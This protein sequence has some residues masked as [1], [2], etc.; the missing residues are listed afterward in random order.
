MPITIWNHSRHFMLLRTGYSIVYITSAPRLTP[1][2]D[3]RVLQ[4]P[5][6]TA[7]GRAYKLHTGGKMLYI[8]HEELPRTTDGTLYIDPCAPNG[9]REVELDERHIP[10]DRY[11]VVETKD[12][13]T[14]PP[15]RY[16]R[17][18]SALRG[19]PHSSATIINPGSEGLH[20][21]EFKVRK[22]TTI[23]RGMHVANLYV[24]EPSNH[25]GLQS[26]DRG[27]YHRRKSIVPKPLD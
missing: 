27:H 17:I 22:P 18:S 26:Y 24:F 1:L 15:H 4:A 9:F 23:Y 6:R 10:A 14:M 2:V 21:L 16:G 25:H 13:I 12:Y 7:N 8:A 5:E 19:C 20:A 3:D 11:I